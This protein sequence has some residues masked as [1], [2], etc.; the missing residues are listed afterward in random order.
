VGVAAMFKQRKG[1]QTRIP[2]GPFLALGAISYLIFSQQLIHIWHLY[3]RTSGL[4]Q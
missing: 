2:Y 3:L 4:G 1:G